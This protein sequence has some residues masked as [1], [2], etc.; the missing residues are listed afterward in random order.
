MIIIQLFS[1]VDM[2]L[3]NIKKQSRYELNNLFNFMPVQNKDGKI[4]PSFVF[5]LITYIKGL[6]EHTSSLSE[7]NF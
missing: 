6:L 7:R 1:I 4:F 5:K 2:N 3:I